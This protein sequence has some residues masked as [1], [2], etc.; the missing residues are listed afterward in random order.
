MTKHIYKQSAYYLIYLIRCVLHNRI[1][2]K[3]K[4]DI[5]NLSGVLVVVKMHSLAAIADYALESAEIHNSAFEEA[6]NKAIRNSIIYDTE[7][8]EIAHALDT[9][10][11]WYMPLK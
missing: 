5:M 8:E 10:R 3:E 1:P 6:K 11:I 4:L 2:A 7:K 9:K